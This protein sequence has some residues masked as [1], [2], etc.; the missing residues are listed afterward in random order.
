MHCN[1]QV[2]K[3]LSL[4]F[5]LRNQMN[6]GAVRQSAGGQLKISKS[7]YGIFNHSDRSITFWD[8]TYH[9]N[10]SYGTFGLYADCFYPK[11]HHGLQHCHL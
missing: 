4:S 3:S 10:D 8:K 6:D 2:S 5:S 9:V 7:T 1:L 11:F